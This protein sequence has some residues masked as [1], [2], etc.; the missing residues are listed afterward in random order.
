MAHDRSSASRSTENGA[1]GWD[2]ALEVLRSRL[3]DV[4]AGNVDLADLRAPV[5]V[6]C[7]L[8][9]SEDVRAEQL[10]V[11]FKEIWAELPPLSGLPR[12][13]Q[14]SD[15]MA[16]FATMCIEEFYASPPAASDPTTGRGGGTREPRRSS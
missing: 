3:I 8:A 11:R 5:R 9:H 15:L 1:S 6:L 7:A 10:L 16:R 4:V 14:R 2:S 13:R 12:G